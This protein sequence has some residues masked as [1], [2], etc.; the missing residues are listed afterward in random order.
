[1]RGLARS[2]NTASTRASIGSVPRVK[3][4]GRLGETAKA[5]G[6]VTDLARIDAR[7]RHL[8]RRQ[9]RH[10][11]ELVAAGGLDDSQAGADLGEMAGELASLGL[12]VGNGR[13]LEGAIGTQH[14]HVERG[15]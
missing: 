11:D 4:E 14:G 2:P 15:G 1:M 10:G 7:D 5:F 8:L 9:R 6:E 12:G 3:P 13:G